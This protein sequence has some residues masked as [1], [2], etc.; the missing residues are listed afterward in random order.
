MGMVYRGVDLS[1]GEIVA[2]KISSSFGSQ[3]G[4]RFQQE[5]NCLATIAH[6]AIVRYIAHGKTGHGEHYLVMEWLDGETLEDRLARGPSTWAPSVQMIR[7][8]A[9]ALAVA[10]QHGVIHRDIKPANIFLPGKDM[11]KIKLLDFGIARRLFDPAS[12][13]LTQAG[14]A[15]GT[16]MYMSP[17]QAQGSLDVDARADVFSLGCVF[18]ECLTGTPP[19]MADSTTGTLAR[20][21][22]DEIRGRGREMRR[23][24]A[25]PDRL[26]RRM[27]AKRPEDGLP[28]WPRSWA[29]WAKSP[30]S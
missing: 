22:T 20:I 16:P 4:E 5:A 25:P 15:L 9:E 10:H 8:V 21:T 14:S 30:K 29:S 24:A 2:V 7:R 26:L 3:L 19:F 1:T 27:L 12:L 11:S 28:P 23:R 13:R 17:E 6:P 18:F